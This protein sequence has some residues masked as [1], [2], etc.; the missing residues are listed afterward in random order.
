MV[1]IKNGNCWPYLL[2]DWNHFWVDAR[3]LGEHLRIAGRGSMIGSVSAWHASGPRVRSPHP[4]C[5][6]VETWS[7]KI[8]YGHS[9]SSADQEEQLSVTGKRMCT[10]YW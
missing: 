4:A 1:K 7:W 5:S 8:F 2:M 10:K 6:V 3:P 9:P